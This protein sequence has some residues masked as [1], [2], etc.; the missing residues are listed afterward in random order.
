MQSDPE[1]WYSTTL[2]LWTLASV[3]VACWTLLKALTEGWRRTVGRRRYVT[4]RLRKIAPGVR[5]DFVESLLGEPRWES[6]MQCRRVTADEQPEEAHRTERTVEITARTWL[7]SNLCYLVTWCEDDLVVMYGITT[8]SWW[9]R[10]WVRIHET[11]VRLG[12]S[13]FASLAD[14]AVTHRA[15]LGNRRF[16]YFEE[17]YF[18]NMGGYRSWYVGV[19]DVGYNAI[20]VTAGWFDDS[21]IRHTVLLSE[22]R[23]RYRASAPINTVVVSGIALYEEVQDG[24]FFGLS[25]G[26]DQDLVRLTDP[27]YHVLDS[28]I[29][30]AQR[31]I[32]V[33]RGTRKS[34]RWEK[35]QARQER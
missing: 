32:R 18:G 30:R 1:P 4:T 31:R 20:P 25:F 3:L 14:H 12:K 15:W 27:E 13:T 9:F 10:P 33:W 29:G 26:A 17:H 34:R 5:H 24:T 28:R 2:N 19:N 16:G 21:D 35:G 22:S 7:L 11:R 23:E 8:A 6:T